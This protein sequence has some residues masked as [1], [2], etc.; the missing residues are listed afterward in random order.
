[1]CGIAG[2]LKFD[3]SSS[4]DKQRLL[5]MRDALVHRGP[6]DAGV[7]IKGQVGLAH[8]RLSIIDLD[9]GHQPMESPDGR[10]WITYNGELYNFKE[11]RNDLK[12]HGCHFTSQSDTE[13]VLQAYQTLGLDC[14]SHLRGMF[15]FAIWDAVE[16]Q[17][18]V[19]RDRLG[20][21]PLY[22][23]IGENEML[24]GSEIKSV[25]AASTD[26]PVFNRAIL[27]EF[28]ASRYVAEDATFF[29]GIQK[30]LPAHT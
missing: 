29:E 2:I 3:S 30:L 19:A 8:R 27:P 16:Q 20:I 13:V 26:T 28:L 15:A 21:K 1:M 6:D 23:A 11:L 10:Y 4:P 18:F 5:A 12:K 17:L 22:F 24:F 7:I 14:V 9:G 25:L